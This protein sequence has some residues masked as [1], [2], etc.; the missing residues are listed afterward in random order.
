MLYAEQSI[1]GLPALRAQL[2]CWLLDNRCTP[3]LIV[4]YENIR[5]GAW[6]G[7]VSA[8]R[9]PGLPSVLKDSIQ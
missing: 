4:L 3:N 6:T 1:L 8:F 5:T 7:T 9:L 2:A